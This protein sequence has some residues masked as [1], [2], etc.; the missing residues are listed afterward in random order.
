MNIVIAGGGTA[1]WLAAYII[2]KTHPN[3]HKL[4]VVASSKIG[5]IGAGENAT[6]LFLDILKGVY[7]DYKVDLNDF[8]EKT[9]ATYKNGIL[10]VN[11]TKDGSDYFTPLGCSPSAN[12]TD[13]FIFKYALA[14]DKDNIHTYSSSGYLHEAKRWEEDL[15]SFHFN[16]HKAG[17]YL[18]N[19]CLEDGVT[20]IDAVISDIPL[21]SSGDIDSLV[22]DNGQ[23]ITGDLFIDATGFSRILMKRLGV[24]WNSYKEYLPV[25]RA[26]PFFLD[27]KEL[28]SRRYTTATALSSG[29]LWNVPLQTRVGAGYTYD[30]NYLSEDQAIEE[31]ERFLGYKVNPIKVIKFDAGATE[32]TWVKNC[33]AVGLAQSFVEPLEAT[34]IHTTI[35]Q[36]LQFTNSYLN[37][38]SKFT[39]VERNKDVFNKTCSRMNNDTLDFISLHY[40]GGRVDSPFWSHMTNDYVATDKV[41]EIIEIAKYNVP[42]LATYQSVLGTA[43]ICLWNWT[44]AGLNLLTPE[45][46][47]RNLDTTNRTEVALNAKLEFNR[48]LG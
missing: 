14:Y 43:P 12:G 17:E 3:Q 4:T 1:G 2:S 44:L 32:K 30:S 35:I 16:S 47:K 38:D 5:I 7:F 42:S 8:M 26:I 21:T 13:D 9:E 46:A 48:R 40:Q 22:L 20:V 34:S 15:Q 27:D 39:M 25:D 24:S 28:M 6:G 29:W 19:I 10:N 11:W 45:M 33:I 41:K 36:L 31:A 23:T 37:V 18:K